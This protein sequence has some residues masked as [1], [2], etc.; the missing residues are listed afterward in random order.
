MD[1]KDLILKYIDKSMTG[2]EIGPSY[3][4][5]CPKRDGWKV[6]SVDHADR[7]ELVR[8]YQG[9]TQQGID[10]SIMEEV[11]FVWRQGSFTT[12][13]KE[14][15]IDRV[16]FIIA[17]HVIEHAPCLV[18]FLQS[19]EELIK[20]DGIISLAIPDKRREFDFLKPLSTTADVIEAY[21]QKRSTH[22]ARSG[23]L[24]FFY[25]CRNRAGL[26]WNHPVAMEE[27]MLAHDFDEARALFNSCD[28]S[29]VAPYLDFHA[30][31]FTPASFEL[32]LLEL[33][34]LHLTNLLPYEV[35]GPVGFEFFV[36]LKYNVNHIPS[37]RFSEKR[38]DLIRKIHAELKESKE[39]ANSA[40]NSLPVESFSEKCMDMI[41][42]I[43]HELNKPA[44]DIMKKVINKTRYY[45]SRLPR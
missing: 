19:I 38:I 8:K 41:R 33:N 6:Y 27:V 39:D 37:D 23:F 42:K 16:D 15:G 43:R 26:V 11:D 31:F 3:N 9:L 25:N 4:P 5:V 14:A 24:H 44:K 36:T 35:Y 18:A 7:A 45:L 32:I 20:E 40:E 17:S 22:S 21:R 29:E 30:W 2:I 34:R 13:F 12:L 1:R 28:F 10:L